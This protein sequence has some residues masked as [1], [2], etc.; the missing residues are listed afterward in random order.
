[1]PDQTSLGSQ[2]QN[3][4]QTDLAY[5]NP[6]ISPKVSMVNPTTM[7]TYP[8]ASSRSSDGNRLKK[9]R[10]FLVLIA[11]S[12]IRY[13]RPRPH[14]SAKPASP[15]KMAT[16][17]EINQKFL[18]IAVVCTVSWGSCETMIITRVTNGAAN[19]PSIFSLNLI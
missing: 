7:Q 18:N 1:M 14:A 12:C 19:T 5:T 3:R 4:P 11:F 9:K 15:I 13:C 6:V 16:T 2:L 17:C 8:V 10:R